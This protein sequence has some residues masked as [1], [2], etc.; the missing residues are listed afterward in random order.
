MGIQSV[1]S[2]F[3]HKKWD[4]VSDIVAKDVLN[5]L[6]EARPEIDENLENSLRFVK[7]E[8]FILSFV[9]S[10]IIS[11]KDVFKVVKSK[12]IAIYFT[13]V[14]YVRL[15]DTVPDDASIRQLTGKYKN[16]VLVC[17]ATF[18]RILNPLGVWKI[19]AIN[20]FRQ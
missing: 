3:Y 2:S 12:N 19:T 5:L 15:S 18:S 8:N 20:F 9:H 7:E 4:Q 10:S 6:I 13:V 16:D 1:A 14:S 11:G 17:N